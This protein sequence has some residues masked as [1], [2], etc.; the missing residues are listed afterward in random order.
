M[1][2]SYKAQI[3]RLI[4]EHYPH[5]GKV[6]FV[7]KPELIKVDLVKDTEMYKLKIEIHCE[8]KI[9]KNR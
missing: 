7:E 2:I 5:Y 1:R 9:I 4:R 8:N 3:R 6:V